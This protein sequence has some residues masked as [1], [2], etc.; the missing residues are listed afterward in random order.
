MLM[1]KSALQASIS[2]LSKQYGPNTLMA[3]D[4]SREVVKNMCETF[5]IAK[6]DRM[7]LWHFRCDQFWQQLHQERITRADHN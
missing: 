2:R 4:G 5:H 7:Q 6:Y 3:M 1:Q